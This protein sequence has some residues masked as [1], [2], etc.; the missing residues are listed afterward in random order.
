M[1]RKWGGAASCMNHMCRH[2]WRG[3]C[4]K[5]TG[6]SFTKIRRYNDPVSLLGTTTSPKSWSSRM[7]TQTL[8]ENRWWCL[9]DTVVWGLSSTQTWVLWSSQ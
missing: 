8:M 1:R 5:I 7:P 4:Y 3:T 9:D 6:K 2:W